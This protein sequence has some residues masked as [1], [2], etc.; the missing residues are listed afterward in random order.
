MESSNRGRVLVVDDEPTVRKLV[1]RMLGRSYD[2]IQAGNGAEAVE[3]A[4]KQAPDLILMDMMMPG[5]DGLS[6]CGALKKDEETKGI[7]VVMLTAVT[8]E[9]NQKLALEIIGASAYVTKPF[10]R[11]VLV[12]TVDQFLRRKV[13]VAASPG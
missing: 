8:H 2:V 9:L 10:D 7:P 13:P 11:E 12:S 4:R 5:L 3:V 1:C 6:A